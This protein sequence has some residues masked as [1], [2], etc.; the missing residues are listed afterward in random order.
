[1]FIQDTNTNSSVHNLFVALIHKSCCIHASAKD[2][3][4]KSFNLNIFQE[5]HE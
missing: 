5:A 1:M 4:G 3:E 2:F